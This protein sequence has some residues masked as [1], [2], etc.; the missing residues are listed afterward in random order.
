MPIR[1]PEKI[2]NPT[3]PIKKKP[4]WIRTKI[5]DLIHFGFFFMGLIGFFTFSGCLARI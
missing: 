5:L 1:H 2:N 4:S 3:N